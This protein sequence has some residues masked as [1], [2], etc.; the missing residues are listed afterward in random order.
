[1]AMNTYDDIWLAVLD[2]CKTQISK[3]GF[4]LWIEPLKLID[5]NG[6]T[7]TLLLA[8][9]MQEK[10]TKSQYGTLLEQAFEEVLGFKVNLE[11]KLCI[12][13]EAQIK[14]EEEEHIKEEKE[15][16]YPF[17]FDTFIEGPSN[18]FAYRAAIAVSE[19]PGGHLIKIILT[20]I[21]IPFSFTANPALA[22]LIFLMQ[23]A[24]KSA[25]IFPR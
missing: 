6:N 11:Y 18:R 16:N 9:P 20:I 2:Y 21:T 24:T 3:T 17:T 13:Q 14:A 10:I 1:M 8:S 23:Y 4:S 5:F 7:I 15:E 22:K 12:E 25:K 19:N